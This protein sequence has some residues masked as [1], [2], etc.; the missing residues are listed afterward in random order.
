MVSWFIKNKI[1]WTFCLLLFSATC[2]SQNDQLFKT[3]PDSVLSRA[4]SAEHADYLNAEEKSIV[5]YTNLVRT[6]PPLF[7]HT[8]LMAYLES[9]N[10]KKDAEIKGLI[11]DLESRNKLEIL[12]PDQ[13]LYE[14]ASMHAQD[15]G[16]S[17]RTGHISSNGE[18]FKDRMKSMS[19]EYSGV[20][21]N[22][23]YGSMNGEEIFF[24]LLIDRNVPNCGHRRNIL[25]PEMKYIGVSIQKHTRFAYN[26]VEDFAGR[27]LE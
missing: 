1:F 13:R 16:Y 21:E 19:N 7:A 15:M 4:N 24:D 11:K 17:G 5:Y 20:N 6:N 2:F 12:I 22:C 8:F 10:M 25:D 14:T 9:N 3:W 18:T 26:C 27:K 23:H